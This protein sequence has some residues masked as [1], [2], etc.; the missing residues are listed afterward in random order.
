[1]AMNPA[2]KPAI[3]TFTGVDYDKAAMADAG[4]DCVKKYIK[5]GRVMMAA[6]IIS[7]K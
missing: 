4:N 6:F 2:G 5:T 1:M 7:S 3:T